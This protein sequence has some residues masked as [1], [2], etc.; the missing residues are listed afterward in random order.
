MDRAWQRIDPARLTPELIAEYQQISTNIATT[1][2]A[3]GNQQLGFRRWQA[4]AEATY[5]ELTEG[6]LAVA[7]SGQDRDRLAQVYDRVEALRG[8]GATLVVADDDAAD[9]AKA[10]AQGREI[11]H[12][13]S[14]L[15]AALALARALDQRLAF[16]E[17]LYQSKTNEADDGGLNARWQALPVVSDARV[18]RTLNDRFDAVRRAEKAA[19]S[20]QLA[21]DKAAGAEAEKTQRA[22]QREALEALLAQAEA[23]LVAGQIVESTALL[24]AIEAPAKAA[25]VGKLG[26]RVA[27][28]RAEVARLKGW[29]HWSGGRAREDLALEAEALADAIKDPKLNVKQ[30]GTAIEKLRERWKDL[31]K[32]G[33]ASSK[34]LWTRFDSALKTA[35]L[36]V[37]AGIAKQKA[38]R[39]ESLK[40]RQALIAGLK[41][42][43]STLLAATPPDWREVTRTL[44]RF[45]TDWR[46][47]GPVEHTVPHKAQAGL[48]ETLKA[49]LQTLEAPLAEA[50]R[51]EVLKRE[52]LVKQAEEIAADTKAR[53]TINRVRALQAE[54]QTLAKAM[55]LARGDENRLWNAFKTA[56]DAVFKARDAVQAARD[57][58]AKSQLSARDALIAQLEALDE[59]TPAA[60]IR[61][62]VGEVD[63]AWRKAGEVPRHLAEKIER[64]Y[65]AA[66]DRARELVSGSATRSWSAVCDTLE[67]KVALCMAVENNQAPQV[68]EDW[69]AKASLPPQWEAALV[70]RRDAKPIVKVDDAARAILELEN[71][72][73]IASPAQ[74]ANARRELKLLAMK[75]A[76]EARESVTAS[77]A[78][79]AAMVGRAIGVATG[80]LADVPRVKAAIAALRRRPL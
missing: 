11:D 44:D 61:K 25:G 42:E 54:W 8:Q 3:R 10:A 75:R 80:D 37:D 70:A 15:E 41:T 58:E 19:R 5:K 67:A 79:I 36:P 45:N 43:A 7:Q 77:N 65:R 71:A 47:L 21:A 18:A 12:L 68:M 14:Q 78:D 9:A 34:E 29:Q 51:V 33:G 76:I 20:A 26:N 2:R 59:S 30:H 63:Q 74:Y 53:D 4:D 22:G 6:C 50:R 23:A 64:R 55:P 66:K 46:K 17:S 62:V 52:K 72:L 1:L 31:D 27:A 60:E 24:A 40:A 57:A 49:A 13:Q 56:T 28:L 32:L 38:A 35:Y 69:A 73:D 16:L 39:Q 48:T